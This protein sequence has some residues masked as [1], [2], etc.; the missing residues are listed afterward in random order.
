VSNKETTFKFRN[1]V[2][3]ICYSKE[4]QKQAAPAR[5]KGNY[6]HIITINKRLLPKDEFLLS[7]FNKNIKEKS[8]Q[9]TI[10]GDYTGYFPKLAI[11]IYDSEIK[12][13][14]GNNYENFDS[15]DCKD[16]SCTCDSKPRYLQLFNNT[17]SER[18]SIL[19]NN[20]KRTIFAA[21]KR[22][23][24]SAPT[25][26]LQVLNEFIEWSKQTID[27]L[28]GD[29]LSDFGYSFNQWINHLTKSKQDR[30]F[31]IH[32]FIN[33]TDPLTEHYSGLNNLDP[34][35]LHY[36]AICKVEVQSIDGKPR[37]VCA[38]PDLIKYVMGPV[39]WKLEE[40]FAQKIPTYCGGQ[41]L[42]QMQDKINHYIDDGFYIAAEGDGSAFDN[43]QDVL[44]KE[45]DRYIYRK[46]MDK[47]YHV[48]KELFEY[49]SQSYYKTMDV[50]LNVDKHRKTLMTYSVLGT[51]FSGDCD[52][53]L[54]NTLRMGFYNWFTNYKLGL[55]LNRDF[56][57]FSKGDDFTVLYKNYLNIEEIK[58]G[59]EKYW[60]GKP[61]NDFDDRNYGLGQ[62]LK[63]I[64]FGYPNS[65][66]FCS[67]RAWYTNYNSMHIFLTRDPSKFLTLA[68]YSRKALNLT[69]E[70]LS[71][72]Y[73]DQAIALLTSYKGIEYFEDMA[74]MYL[75]YAKLENSNVMSSNY[76]FN[77]NKLNRK[78]DKR[79]TLLIEA[80]NLYDGYSYRPRDNY[81]KIVGNYWETMKNLETKQETILNAEELRIV[82][83]QI[84]TEFLDKPIFL[85]DTG[86]PH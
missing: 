50:I 5:F 35:L 67:L 28:I 40:L 25:P 73:C 47:I 36:E 13:L 37:M 18:D 55:K 6:P 70:R 82:N 66:K 53:T 42:T 8:L 62:I 31:K 45:L 81:V 76:K 3:G 78:G 86:L 32:E 83:D 19:Y 16:I 38:I 60:L 26:N 2:T 57:C 10:N 68:K 46:I 72:Y 79:Q 43:T 20:C 56:V 34:K 14:A 17:V 48:P 84:N 63:F 21:A 22:Q 49:I 51:V 80:Q 69:S 58:K 71:E 1:G 65:I 64:E 77:N 15:I 12:K 54:M 24:K 27:E 85:L 30:M 11:V 23:I 7:Q 33:G 59:Y 75:K 74:K 44:L 39:C 9:T 4:M 61:E 29:D 52:T 41:N